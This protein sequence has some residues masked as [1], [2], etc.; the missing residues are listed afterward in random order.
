MPLMRCYCLFCKIIKTVNLMINSGVQDER[1]SNLCYVTF[2]ARMFRK[3]TRTSQIVI[4]SAL[5][6][7][8]SVTKD[9]K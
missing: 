9:K 4:I 2:M 5:M 1:H 6:C 8:A 3:Q 7:I